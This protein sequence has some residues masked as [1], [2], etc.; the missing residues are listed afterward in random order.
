[1]HRREISSVE[2]RV[3]QGFN[4]MNSVLSHRWQN[5]HACHVVACHRGSQLAEVCS[6]YQKHL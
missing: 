3:K 4:T 6:I 2:I 5:Y 1:M